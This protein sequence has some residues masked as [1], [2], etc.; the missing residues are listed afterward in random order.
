[1]SLEYKSCKNC[2]SNFR[3]SYKYCPE[4]GMKSKEELTLGVLFYNTI[5]NYLLYDSK[6]FKSFIPLMVKPGFLA[7]KF[8]AGKRLSFLHPAQLYLFVTFIFFFMFSF[9]TN[10]QELKL[11][12]EFNKA[13]TEIKNELEAQKSDSLNRIELY[14]TLK[15]TQHFTGQNDKVI[16]SIVANTDFSKSKN[17]ISFGY[18]VKKVD[19]LLDINAPKNDIYLEMGMHENPYWIEKIIYPQVL[20]FHQ[21]QN[22]GT[23]WNSMIK[24][25]PIALFILLPIFALLLKIFYYNKGKYA[26][27]LVFTFYFFSYLF[28]VFSILLIADFITTVPGWIDLLI[29][30]S[31]FIY[32]VIALKK[33]YNQGW[34]L[35]YLK[36]ALITFFFLIFVMPI[37]FVALGF[38]T[39]LMY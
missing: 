6:F 4:C 31:T 29:L 33:F 5:N 3:S 1:M 27:H 18:D 35:S 24:A 21:E 36:S 22:I 20:K 12:Q 28:V 9:V 13:T 2:D 23:I 37:A 30:L 15:K 16:D 26:Y 7:N 14:N 17:K 38:I 25:T 32:L 11:N 8:I 34:F 10:K 39:F 19:S